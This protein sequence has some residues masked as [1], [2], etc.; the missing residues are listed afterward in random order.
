MGGSYKK[1]EVYDDDTKMLTTAISSV[2][3]SVRGVAK[4]VFVDLLEEKVRQ[5][6]LA[7]PNLKKLSRCLLAVSIAW[8]GLGRFSFVGLCIG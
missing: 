4:R 3:L 2:R 8:N 5:V 6:K 7:G 1:Q